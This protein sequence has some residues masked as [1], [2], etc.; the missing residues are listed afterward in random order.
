MYGGD[1]GSLPVL[2]ISRDMSAAS[3]L[4]EQL[5]TKTQVAG[6]PL[7]DPMCF[8]QNLPS[9]LEHKFNYLK[10]DEIGAGSYGVVYAA[11]DFSHGWSM[12]VALKSMLFED[13]QAIFVKFGVLHTC[14]CC[15]CSNTNP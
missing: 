13:D 5:Q 3:Q 11:S 7:Q 14:G 6:V 8:L 1:A 10:G 9:W 4:G 2:T 15:S 12:S